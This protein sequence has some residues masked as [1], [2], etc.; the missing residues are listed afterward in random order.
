MVFLSVIL[1][2]QILT[3]YFSKVYLNN[4]FKLNFNYNST[5]LY[6]NNM[7]LIKFFVIMYYEPLQLYR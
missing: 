6:L 4:K 2:T 3:K 7:T 1:H 5:S